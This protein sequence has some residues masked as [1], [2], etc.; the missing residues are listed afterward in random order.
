MNHIGQRASAAAGR[1]LRL[2]ADRFLD[3]DAAIRRVARELYE[4]TRSLPL[5]CPH[6]HVDP[7][8]LA[9]NSRR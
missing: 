3:P 1:P 9:N 2:H 5:V 6:G 4:E 8:L 7:S